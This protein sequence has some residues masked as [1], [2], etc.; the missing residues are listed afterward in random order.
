MDKNIPVKTPLSHSPRNSW[1]L[2]LMYG[3]VKSE[4]KRE[5]KIERESMFVSHSRL[6]ELITFIY[7]H[8][9]THQETLI[10]I[11]PPLCIEGVS[12]KRANCP[13]RVNDA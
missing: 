3:S 13:W 2:H 8:I 12:A 1:F 9:I 6:G 4:R 11:N 7:T 5:G 10:V